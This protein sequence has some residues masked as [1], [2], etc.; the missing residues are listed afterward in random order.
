MRLSH[1]SLTILCLAL[2]GC[3]A[4]VTFV[5]R[6]NGDEFVGKTGATGGG[7]GEISALIEGDAYTGHWI[8]SA[9]GGGYSLGVGFGSFGRSTALVTSTAVD[10]S[11]QGNGLVNMKSTNGQ[12]M[13]CVFNFNGLSNTGIGECERNDGRLY[14]LRIKR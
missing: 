13:R 9:N 4:R 2:S 8:V 1:L 7:E 3:A 5:D 6:S 12:L 10:V 11:A 14:D